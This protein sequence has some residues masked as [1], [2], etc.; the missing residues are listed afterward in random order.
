MD[1]TFTNGELGVISENDLRAFDVIGWN[2]TSA[3]ATAVPEPSN[4]IGTLMFAGF[5]AKLA[6]KRRRKLAELTAKSF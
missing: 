1:P 3:T 6:L 2:R 4:I 5:G